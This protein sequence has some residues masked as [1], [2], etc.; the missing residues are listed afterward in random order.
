MKRKKKLK[1]TF[2]SKR[3]RGQNSL[4]ENVSGSAL[5]LKLSA[6]IP[7]TK[8]FLHF[9][10]IKR[11]S[12]QNALAPQ[13]LDALDPKGKYHGAKEICAAG[14]GRSPKLKTRC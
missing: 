6:N 13:T 2:Q 7:H 11:K 3:K 8:P 12:R 14:T 10:I 1:L 9:T 4:G 5:A